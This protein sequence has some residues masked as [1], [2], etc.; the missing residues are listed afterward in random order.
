M[1][2][3][4][5]NPNLRREATLYEKRLREFAIEVSLRKDLYD[6]FEAFR[7][8]MKNDFSSLDPSQRRLVELMIR[9]MKQSGVWLEGEPFERV[10]RLKE[11]LAGLETQFRKNLNENTDRIFI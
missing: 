9:D 5:T 6:A 7:S 3:V 11:E 1:K 2:D 8:N 10:R 4:S